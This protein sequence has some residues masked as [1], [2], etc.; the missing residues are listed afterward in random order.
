MK[1][2]IKNRVSEYRQEMVEMV[3]DLISIPT[4]NP[5]GDFY[6]ECVNYLSNRLTEWDIDFELI[7]ITENANSGIAILG[8]YGSGGSGF[9]FHGHY[10]VVPAQ[11]NEQYQPLVKNEKIYGSGSSDM[12]GGLVSMLYAI[13]VIKE[14]NPDLRGKLT[15][16]IVPDEETGGELGTAYL[17]E[18]EILPM[19]TIGMLMPEATSSKIWNANKGAYTIRVNIK[20]KST[21]AALEN[22]GINA[23]EKMINIV[24]SYIE[25]NKTIKIRKTQ[26]NISPDSAKRSVMVLGGR[27]GSGYNFNVVPGK[28]FF[29]IDRRFNPEE[30]LDEVREELIKVIDEYKKLGVEIDIDVMQE[31]DSSITEMDNPLTIVLKESIEDV[32]GEIPA[33]ELCPGICE[34][35]FFNDAGIPAFAYG[36]GLLEVSHGPEEFVKIDD[37]VDCAVV[38]AK[39]ALGILT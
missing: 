17:F 25:L 33:F 35:R 6:V 15:F 21:H 16:S 4:P 34:I 13:R 28:A 18:K 1:N 26:L 8:E 3:C 38:Y 27:S 23:F 14:T 30:T 10:D 22:S 31:G 7:Q 29:T 9:H 12:K 19:G 37:I 5:P 36:P 32:R 24:K 20:G 11:S 39:T 2:E